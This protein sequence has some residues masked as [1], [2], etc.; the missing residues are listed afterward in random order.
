[1][2]RGAVTKYTFPNTKHTLSKCQI[3]DLKCQIRFPLCLHDHHGQFKKSLGFQERELH[4]ILY[5][6]DD[7]E[8]WGTF[9]TL[10]IIVRMVMVMMMIIG[11]FIPDVF[12]EDDDYDDGT[13]PRYF[14]SYKLGSSD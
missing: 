5:I 3:Y 6:N 14:E 12:N 8:D 13:L 7:H 10:L 11:T 1:M 4:Q 2:P 9:L